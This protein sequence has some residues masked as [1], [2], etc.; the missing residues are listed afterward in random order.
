MKWE[1]TF[2]LPTRFAGLAILLFAGS[3]QT[4]A[5]ETA[6]PPEVQIHEVAS[7]ILQQAKKASCKPRTCRILVSDFVVPSGLMSQFGLQLADQFS[8]ELASQQKGIQ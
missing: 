5:Q 8:K 6:P 2:S 1:S 7:R 3:V 4:T